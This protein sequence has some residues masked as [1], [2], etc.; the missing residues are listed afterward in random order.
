MATEVVIIRLS[1]IGDVVHALPVA[2]LLKQQ[3]KDVR[4]TWVVEPAASQLVL[5][6][7]AV[8]EVLIF[9]GKALLRAF[10]PFSRQQ[11]KLSESFQFMR[12]LRSRH[13]DLA[14]DAQGL[15]KSGVLAF[16]SGA[17]LR[18]GFKGAREFSDRLMTHLVDV[19][20]YFG[21]SRHVVEHNLSLAQKAV[22]LLNGNASGVVPV[23]FPLPKINEA[24]ALRVKELLET[25]LDRAP[26]VPPTV[27][28]DRAPNLLSSPLSTATDI[29]SDRPDQ[30]ASRPLSS[31]EKEGGAGLLHPPGKSELPPNTESSPTTT[32]SLSIVSRPS[33]GA[34]AKL[35]GESS[36][37]KES[38]RSLL[39]L[40]PSTTW[41][42]KI[43]PA[44]RWIGLARKLIEK[45]NY[46]ILIVGG[47]QDLHGNQAIERELLSGTTGR[48]ANLTGR[49]SIVDLIALF[50]MTDLVIGADT[51]PLHIAAATGK[52][53]VVGIF[54]STPD[55]RNG[56]YGQQCWTIALGLSCQ[57][58]FSKICPLGTTACLKEMSDQYV[59]D[60]LTEMVPLDS[61]G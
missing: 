5:D 49:T 31:P 60:K 3:V 13:F 30:E 46:Q 50:N 58:C 16:L 44:D 43:W 54:G 27:R 53:K 55:K 34:K 8:N 47:S 51:G 41:P 37:G 39:V 57:P 48:V 36:N 35:L 24:S 4:I 19:G 12:A 17:P 33:P 59:F 29:K 18:L 9:P 61:S 1:A 23:E 15:F 22:E 42:S 45:T 21:S 11:E 14:I 25:A 28:S 52:P 20:D 26:N 10:H 40:I 7:A 2:A 38:P 32:S 6:N 56:P